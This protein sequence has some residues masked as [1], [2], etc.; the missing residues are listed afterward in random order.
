[1]NDDERTVKVS[2]KSLMRREEYLY[3]GV[4]KRIPNWSVTECFIMNDDYSSLLITEVQYT[5]S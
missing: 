1:M 4:I 3:R 2:S 5:P